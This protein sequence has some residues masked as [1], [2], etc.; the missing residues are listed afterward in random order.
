MYRVYRA[1][2]LAV[3]RRRRK[4]V[5]GLRLSV[6]LPVRVNQRWSMDF[7]T[8]VLW[9]G[10][11]FRMLTVVDDRTRECLAIEIDTSLPRLRVV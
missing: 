2:G 4:R 10:R 6:P 11:A 9:T 7:V 3:R 8:D 1:E 5:A